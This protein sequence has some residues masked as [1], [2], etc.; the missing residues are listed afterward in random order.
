[1]SEK[2]RT[3][4]RFQFVFEAMD[5]ATEESDDIAY[6]AKAALTAADEF[7][8]WQSSGFFVPQPAKRLAVGDV[9]GPA[10]AMQR[11]AV[12]AAY[13]VV[14]HE[15]TARGDYS[16]FIAS[17]EPGDEDCTWSERYEPDERVW[18]RQ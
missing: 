6:L 1:M 11:G 15:L 18:I 4:E 17:T 5:K 7:D 9:F 12:G 3:A 14:S 10:D 13:R 16:T 8:W 2:K